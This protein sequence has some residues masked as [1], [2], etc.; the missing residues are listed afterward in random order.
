[1]L[2]TKASAVSNV[3]NTVPQPKTADLHSV[4]EAT[5]ISPT[6]TTPYKDL[7]FVDQAIY[8]LVL[9]GRICVVPLLKTFGG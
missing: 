4:Y 5:V 7:A 6:I 2:L 9:F 3:E 8:D 1:M